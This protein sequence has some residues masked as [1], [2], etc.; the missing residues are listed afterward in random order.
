M[1]IAPCW[2]ALGFALLM[3]IRADSPAEAA[4]TVA[5]QTAKLT[6]IKLKAITLSL[7]FNNATID[8]AVNFLHV[9]AK[10]LDPERAG[11]NFVISPDAARAAKPVTLALNGVSFEQALQ[12]V[13]GLAGV[14]YVVEDRV[15]R[16]LAPAEK[17][18]GAVSGLPAAALDDKAA[19]AT[20][21]KLQSIVIDRIN[22]Q[23]LDIAAAVQFLGEKSR[24]LDP[25]HVGIN[26]VLGNIDS[27]A[28]VHRALSLTL[29][30]IPL[31]DLIREIEA[32]AN[33][34]ASINGTIVTFRPQAR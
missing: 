33:L 18:P 31:S 34:H 32:Q 9:E 14:K 26:F 5:T 29:D 1:K 8:E 7:D 25:D 10:R 23:N 20:M 15:I 2:F 30:N 11:F 22:F 28:N 12:S 13:C 4:P 6:A 16:I 3:P 24:E 27:A 19:Q 17:A 21:H